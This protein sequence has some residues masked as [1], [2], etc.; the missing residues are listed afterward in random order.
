MCIIFSFSSQIKSR[1]EAAIDHK[2]EMPIKALFYRTELWG[3][4]CIRHVFLK[5]PGYMSLF[6]CCC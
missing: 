6:D 4:A 3:G 2:M 5:L 1:I